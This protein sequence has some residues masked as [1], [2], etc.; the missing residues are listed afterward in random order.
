MGVNLYCQSIG[1]SKINIQAV[2]VFGG[3]E[4]HLALDG[5][6]SLGIQVVHSVV[7][8]FLGS[9]FAAAIIE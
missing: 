5:P 7:H 3:S 4:V 1:V 8:C 9:T 2:I 6:A